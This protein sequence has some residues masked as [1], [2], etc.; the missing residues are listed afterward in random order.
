MKMRT[1]I[2]HVLS[3]MSSQAHIFS[4]PNYI[5]NIETSLITATT[6]PAQRLTKVQLGRHNIR[7]QR[8]IGFALHPSSLAQGIAR[9]FHYLS[10]SYLLRC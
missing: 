4:G 8:R 6:V 9:I 2:D 5:F 1:F 3:P 7:W 10:I